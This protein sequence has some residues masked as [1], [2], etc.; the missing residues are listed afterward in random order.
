M[1]R[2]NIQ[3]EALKERLKA[4]SLKQL[5]EAANAACLAAKAAAPVETGQLRSSISVRSDGER[6][7]VGT[8]CE[9]AAAVEFGTSRRAARPFLSTAARTGDG[10]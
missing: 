3:T 2:G 6:F 10:S 5:E 9:Y 1:I 8:D 4:V 7:F